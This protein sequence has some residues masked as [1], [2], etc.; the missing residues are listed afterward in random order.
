MNGRCAYWNHK[1]SYT[2]VSLAYIKDVVDSWMPF[3]TELFGAN[4]FKDSRMVLTKYKKEAYL[5]FAVSCS[6]GVHTM[7]GY[8]LQTGRLW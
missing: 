8:I 3:L 4:Q 2:L 6:L 5:G 1:E 7:Q